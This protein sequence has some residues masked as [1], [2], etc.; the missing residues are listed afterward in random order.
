MLSVK[1]GG[2]ETRLFSQDRATL[3]C[4][5]KPGFFAASQ[6]TVGKKPGFFSQDRATLPC[7]KKPGFWAK[8]PVGKKPGFFHRIG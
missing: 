7:R 8:I 6:I 1:Y 5:K 2:K 4:R 3:P